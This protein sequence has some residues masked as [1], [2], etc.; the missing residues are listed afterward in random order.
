MNCILC[1]CVCL[2][3]WT[4]TRQFCL[5]LFNIS[6]ERQNDTF[7][8]NRLIFPP[9]KNYVKINGCLALIPSQQ[10]NRN[11]II[12]NSHLSKSQQF[13]VHMPFFVLET[14][15]MGQTCVKLAI[16]L[17]D[18]CSTYQTIQRWW[19]LLHG[20]FNMWVAT[21]SARTTVQFRSSFR[22]WGGGGG[23]SFVRL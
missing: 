21:I 4:M 13:S 16:L 9:N 20:L 15:F 1:V 2:C 10:P 14:Q 19:S 5:R 17:V 22:V 11:F 23:S 6:T 18:A 12:L 8:L 7:K 3:V